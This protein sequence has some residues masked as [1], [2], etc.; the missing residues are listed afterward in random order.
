MK[1]I[2]TI[3]VSV[4]ILVFF[5]TC[6]VFLGPDPD[7]SPQGIFDSIWNDFD[8]NY[9]LFD[10]KGINW[11]TIYNTY[12]TNIFSDMNDSELFSVCSDMLGELNDAHV[13]LM[14]SFDYFNSGSKFNTLNVEPFSLDLIKSNY[15]NSDY[16]LVGEGMFLYGT[17]K[18]KP[19]VGYI[20]I[21][22]FAYG[23]TTGVNQDW[24]K[25]IDNV[26]AKMSSTDSLI[27]DIRGNRGGLPGNVDYIASRFASDKKDY[28]QVRTKNGPNQNDFSSPVNY[29]II[30]A[31][32]RY[33]KSIMLITNA[34]TISAGEWFTLALRSQNHVVHTGSSTCGAF[35]LALERFLINGWAYNI[36]VQ[37]VTDMQGIC[38]E[39]TG[40]TPEHIILNDEIEF[41]AG[42]DAQLEYAISIIN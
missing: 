22:G 3:F 37:K 19:S 23:K 26:V 15:L 12:V 34:Q 24:I 9:A 18:T 4:F 7:N 10:V 32:A 41:A 11:K 38:Y 16:D 39:G 31:G 6:N 33:T 2:K 17:F 29:T 13:N 21:S 25:A 5:S 20:F 35:S 27:L 36:S 8:K 1:C 14:S 40:I 30:P 42:K 28:T